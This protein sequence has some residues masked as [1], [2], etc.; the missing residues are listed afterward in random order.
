MERFCRLRC[1]PHD[2][3]FQIKCIFVLLFDEKMIM[4]KNISLIS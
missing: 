4:V 2:L 1:L 3:F